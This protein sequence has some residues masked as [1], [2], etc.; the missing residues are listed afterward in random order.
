VAS[1]VQSIH[2]GRRWF[3]Q[4]NLEDYV[5][6]WTFAVPRYYYDRLLAAVIRQPLLLG[7]LELTWC[8]E[9]SPQTLR[10]TYSGIEGFLSWEQG[11]AVIALLLP[12]GIDE[13]TRRTLIHSVHCLL[14]LLHQAAPFAPSLPSFECADSDASWTTASLSELPML[15]SS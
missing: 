3:L 2:D 5:V 6:A 8:P 1:L 12:A 11:T 10:V 15:P 4:S 7:G 9:L 14:F 13:A